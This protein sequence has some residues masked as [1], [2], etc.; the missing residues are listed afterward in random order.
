MTIK[1][2]TLGNLNRYA[3]EMDLALFSSNDAGMRFKCLFSNIETYK[4]DQFYSVY[5]VPA[6]IRLIGKKMDLFTSTLQ[7]E[8]TEQSKSMAVVINWVE[9]K[10][11]LLVLDLTN[12]ELNEEYSKKV[13]EI[14][15]LISD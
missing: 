9:E 5:Q 1:D 3:E 7:K 13:E 14:K 4:E 10:R 11:D 12:E 15:N 2:E 8:L 6:L